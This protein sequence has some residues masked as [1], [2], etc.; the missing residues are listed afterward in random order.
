M[1]FATRAVSTVGQLEVSPNSR[2][3]IPGVVRF[4]V[5]PRHPDDATLALMDE[6]FRAAAGDA[7]HGD[8]VTLTID[9]IWHARSAT[10]TSGAICTLRCSSF[11]A[12]TAACSRRFSPTLSS[13]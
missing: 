3:T 10:P 11:A 8:S 7:A 5:D 9:E 12:A 1:P 13:P 4:T 6:V 2:T